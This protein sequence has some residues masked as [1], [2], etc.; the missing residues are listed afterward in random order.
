MAV[1]IERSKSKNYVMLPGFV[2]VCLISLFLLLSA[3]GLFPSKMDLEPIAWIVLSILFISSAYFIYLST[4]QLNSKK[5]AFIIDDQ[6]F[7]YSIT[8]LG[9]K[10]GFIEWKDIKELKTIEGL[11]NSYI[12]VIVHNP[13]KY[14][15]RI[16]SGFLKKQTQKRL[17]EPNKYQNV[18]LTISASGLHEFE[19]EELERLLTSKLNAY[20]E[21]RQNITA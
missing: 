15:G 2:I 7:T 8:A 14:L 18:L 6:G 16:K 17:F 20:H 21:A 9:Y 3:L 13:E 12:S 4:K 5:A 1:R 19:F 11:G 10:L